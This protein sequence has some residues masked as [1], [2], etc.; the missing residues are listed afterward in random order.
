MSGLIPEPN[1]AMQTQWISKAPLRRQHIT[2]GAN[3]N[4]QI[5]RAKAELARL[6][7]AK[8]RLASSNLL[9]MRIDD[10]EISIRW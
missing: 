6:E 5:D 10:L 3:I 9:D 8:E 2:I 7:A 1:D 4:S